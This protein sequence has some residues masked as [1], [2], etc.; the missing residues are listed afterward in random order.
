MHKATNSPAI[1]RAGA[2]VSADWID[3]AR[4]QPDRPLEQQRF[5][6]D[7]A[8]HKALCRWLTQPGLAVR[9]AV[10]ASGIYSLD[11]TLALHQCEGIAVMLVNPRAAKDYRRSRMQRSKTDKVDAAM[12]CDYALRPLCPGRP[13]NQPSWSCGKWRG[14]SR[15]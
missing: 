3:A 7:G 10:E 9:I 15:R 11:L 13:Q 14:A 2:D 5:A 1:L 8:G 4:H 12:L 6:N